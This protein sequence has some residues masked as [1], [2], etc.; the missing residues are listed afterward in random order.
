M[1]LLRDAAPGLEVLMLK[2]HGASR[3][4]GGASVFPGG[5]VDANDGRLDASTHFDV[6][7]AVLHAR[8]GEAGIDA[9]A[10][11]GLYVAAL[12]ETMEECGVLLAHG[13]GA[14]ACAVA[15]SRLRTG[16]SF[17]DMLAELR[18]RLMT[19][20]MAPW[21]RW[22]T[23]EHSLNRRF[24]TRF[25][26]ARVPADHRACHDGQET[27][28]S[29]WVGPRAA[30]ETYWGGGMTLAPPQIMT[31]AAL[32]RYDSVDAVLE[33]GLARRP[34]LIQPCVLGDGEARVMC[35]P[36]DEAH[37]VSRRAMPGPLRLFV[38]NE[39]YEPQTGFDG[40]FD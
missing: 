21:S 15:A 8:L 27:T 39:R 6:P 28:E 7:V 17:N 20:R 12:R 22:I 35:Y 26:V 29:V 16:S 2:R 24:D 18:F 3:T 4:L 32:A 11:A 40:F 5:K 37:P 19:G 36:G 14:E 34:P 10:A 38:R 1:I 31:L 30:L 9:A 33:A 25:F 13:V 23:P